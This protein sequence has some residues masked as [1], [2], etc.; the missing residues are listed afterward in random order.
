MLF[1][2]LQ[3]LREN[4]KQLKQNLE[5][6]IYSQDE[7]IEAVCDKIV[8]SY[9]AINT[10]QPKS[11]FFFLGPPATGKSMLAKALSKYL[12]GYEKCRIFDMTQYTSANQ[13]FGLFGLT[14][15]YNNAKE[16]QLTSYVKKYPK[17]IIVFDEIEKAHPQ[18]LSNFLLLLSS[19]EIKD[20][21]SEEI[22]DFRKTILIF[23]SNLGSELY[24]NQSFIDMM[25]KDSQS[26][27]NSI[28]E[29]ISRET[30]I[31]DGKEVKALTPE[32]LSRLSQ[33]SIV[34]FKKLS[35]EALVNISKN[36]LLKVQER[37]EKEF[38]LELIYDGFDKVVTL[39]TLSFSPFV[40][41]RRIKSH[42]HLLIFDR[43]TD[44]L[45]EDDKM[46]NSIKISIDNDSKNFI[47]KNILTLSKN[48]QDKYLHSLFRKN[49]T[50]SYEYEILSDNE[51]IKLNFKNVKKKKIPKSKDFAGES[52]L[53]F[54]VPD[55]SFDDI[56]GHKKAK[57]RLKEAISVLKNPNKLR[58]FFVEVPKGML[59]YGPP[60]T[61]KTMLAKA[62]ANEA[63]MPFISTTGSDLY[64]IKL[65]KDIFK[66]AKEYAPSI[67]FIDEVDA[68]GRRDGSSNDIIINKLLTELNGFSDNLEENI[69]IIMAT[70]LK[71]K[72]DPAILRSGRIDLHIKIDHLD[73]EARKFFID[74]ILKKP[75]KGKFD[76]DKLLIYTAGMT[77]ADLQKVS[78]ESS[79]YVLRNKLDAITQ[80]ILIEQ[81]NTIK[82]GERITHS[83]LDRVVSSTAIH[84]SGHAVL[85][86]VLM[87][88]VKIEQITV[89]PRNDA[90]GFVSYN[91]EDNINNL[92]KDDIKNK[93]CIAFAGREAQLKK[94][95]DIGYDSGASSDLLAA[96]NYAYSAIAYLGMGENCGYINV[97]QHE[98]LFAKKIEDEVDLWLEEAQEKTKK[99]IEK[100]WDKITALANLLE[101][102]EIVSE[103]ELKKLMSK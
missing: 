98:K 91:N 102:Q 54:E 23:T 43:I 13:G 33:G 15:G 16:G 35:L 5:T 22:I 32:I 79:L 70:N 80:D 85:S 74:K 2:Q 59:L 8:E 24:N 40:D 11:I 95:G 76:I 84:E 28:I 61:G 34:L 26:A 52:A 93:L 18:V 49:E 58:K 36:K 3:K 99:L 47:E 71:E 14:E 72:I 20:E 68:I 30:K 51:I 77:G 19:G 53:V 45:R 41:P 42:I 55:I 27:Q 96:T 86:M 44:F 73:K 101:K 83:S 88:E 29:A 48:Q 9:Y 87:P 39:L 60:G 92:T 63:G 10:N 90:L 97:Q 94:Y 25:K 65:L 12:D 89:T 67:V 4:I 7:A 62:F 1:L 66:K 75:T 81:I 6:E 78:R 56:A 57:E 82:Y 37:F 31:V 64:D 50:I 69:F 100:Y 46:Y 38:G 17:S 103:S 21:Y